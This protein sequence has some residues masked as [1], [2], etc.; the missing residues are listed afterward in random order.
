MTLIF[1]LLL[2]LLSLWF[3]VSLCLYRVFNGGYNEY[4]GEVQYKFI[5]LSTTNRQ[6]F[7][8]LLGNKIARIEGHPPFF[9][10]KAD[11]LTLWPEDLLVMSKEGHTLAVTLGAKSLFFG[12]VSKAKVISTKVINEPPKIRK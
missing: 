9:V 3:L 5:E 11:H 7:E 4:Y 2:G 8:A 12:G 10:S 1:L 6:V